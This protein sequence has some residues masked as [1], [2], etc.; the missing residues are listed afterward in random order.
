LIYLA[1]VIYWL[2]TGHYIRPIALMCALFL[3]L[4]LIWDKANLILFWIVVSPLI[5]WMIWMK[6][7]PEAIDA[8]TI[9]EVFDFDRIVILMVFIL[10]F[11]SKLFSIEAR[12]KLEKSTLV[13][14]SI[15]SFSSVLVLNSL[16]KS[17]HSFNA[18]RIAFDSFIIPSMGFYISKELLTTEHK[19]KGLIRA[20]LILSLYIV[21][22]GIIEIIYT[23]NLF[24]RIRWPFPF[25][26]TYGFILC[27][28]FTINMFP[29]TMTNRLKEDLTVFSKLGILLLFIILCI[30]LT[31]TRAVWITFIVGGTFFIYRTRNIV[32]NPF[33]KVFVILIISV[34]TFG[35]LTFVLPSNFMTKSALFKKRINK[36][37]TIDNRL[38]TYSF[39]LQQVAKYPLFGIGF[40]NFRDY[41]GI[42]LMKTGEDKFSNPG[43]STLHCSYIKILTETGFVG[44]TFFILLLLGFT[45]RIL[46]F[47]HSDFISIRIWG[48]IG[49]TTIIIY[50]TSALSYDPLFDPPFFINKLFFIIMGTFFSS[51]TGFLYQYEIK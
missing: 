9:R 51:N 31:L 33:K 2:A 1:L 15:I 19:F 20:F 49:L 47:T 12:K 17:Y 29:Y 43:R 35:F 48:Y 14:F 45:L 27:L 7:S 8:V 46:S 13:Y 25:W 4:I 16:F 11:F 28:L 38:E 5:N 37:S 39:A 26:E 44:L 22:L 24:R 6:R 23:G 34:L 21:S 10:L 32:K 18:L 42:T 41:Y 3:L 36:T 50:I 30:F 40:Q